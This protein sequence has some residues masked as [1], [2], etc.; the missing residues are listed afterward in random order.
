[1]QNPSG[2]PSTSDILS[3]VHSQVDE[4]PSIVDID[5]DHQYTLQPSG[6]TLDEKKVMNNSVSYC[7]KG[8]NCQCN[9]TP[10]GEGGFSTQ[11]NFELSPYLGYYMLGGVFL[12]GFSAWYFLI[13]K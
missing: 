7:G 4:A 1:M 6:W 10:A 12:L 11:G 13:R 3:S 2:L 5:W 8:P 9:K